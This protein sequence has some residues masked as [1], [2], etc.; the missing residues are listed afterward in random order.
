MADIIS[1]AISAIFWFYFA[2]V[3]GPHNYGQVTYLLSIAGISAG[4]ASFGANQTLMVLSAKKVEI[5]KIIYILALGL[6]A[7]SS[8]VL[9]VFLPEIGVGLIILGQI[10]LTVVT[11]SIL[12][13]KLY[14]RY[15]KFVIAQKILMIVFGLIFYKLFQ[16]HGIL[17]GI[18]ISYFPFIIEI[19][20]TLKNSRINLSLLKEKKTFVFNN[21]IVSLT[22][23]MYSSLDKLI[24][25]PFLGYAVLG[26]YSLGYQFFFMLYVIPSVIQKYLIPHESTGN[27]NK[28]IKKIV[29][30]FSI[31]IAVLGSLVG[32]Q[33]VSYIF[34]KFMEVDNIIRIMSWA[35]IPVTINVVIFYPKFWAYE[36]N[37]K[38][39]IT[40]IAIVTIQVIGI[41]TLGSKYS[42]DGV[43][44]A[45]LI[46]HV[47]GLATAIILDKFEL[48]KST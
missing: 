24:I 31:V 21:F 2:S 42:T 39:A 35:I 22:A 10:M 1:S 29:V 17:I 43:A 12:G 45:F 34:P 5:E 23:T 7:C 32:P 6:G 33:I 16:E 3:L 47:C 48:K 28:K 26:N 44:Y 14:R 40:T 4:I 46:A 37:Y 19:F 25:A 13:K 38:V 18:G 15:S 30:L 8:L 20:N 27:Q 36:K 9:F 41:L 11:G